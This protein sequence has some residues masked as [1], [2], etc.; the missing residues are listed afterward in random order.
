MTELCYSLGMRKILLPMLCVVF[1]WISCGGDDDTEAE[2]TP[3]ALTGIY[4]THEPDKTVYCL[5]DEFDKT[6]MVVTARYSDGSENDVTDSV[7]IF[8]FN[9]DYQS[10]QTLTVAY[11]ENSKIFTTACQIRVTNYP[12]TRD[13]T[14][15]VSFQYY[16]YENGNWQLYTYSDDPADDINGTVTFKFN[17]K[18]V[19]YYTDKNSMLGHFYMYYPTTKDDAVWQFMERRRAD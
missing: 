11:A 8:G 17:E 12:C 19:E 13:R 18:G 15:R 10:W 7:K 14:V 6:G 2:K 4:M 9:S 3:A 16:K 1:L 5:Y